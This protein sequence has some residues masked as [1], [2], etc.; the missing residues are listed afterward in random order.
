MPAY[1]IVGGVP[2]K[3]IKYRFDEKTISKLLELKW[4]TLPD[5]IIKQIPFKDIKL[6][7]KFLE[8]KAITDIDQ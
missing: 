6:A 8:N 5:D 3:I 2:A 1:A 4:W 7:I